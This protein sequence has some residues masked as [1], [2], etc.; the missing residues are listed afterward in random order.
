M[1]F[2]EIINKYISEKTRCFVNGLPDNSET[3]GTII[4]RGEDYIEFEMLNIQT[5]KK[6]GKLKESKELKIIPIS[7]ISDLSVGEIVRETDAFGGLIK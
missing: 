4:A 1:K 5:E 6:T 3:K 2:D 7:Q